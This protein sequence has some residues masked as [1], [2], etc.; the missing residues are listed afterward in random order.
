MR[1][2]FR[3]KK[4]SFVPAAL[5]LG[6]VAICGAQQPALPQAPSGLGCVLQFQDHYI[7]NREAFQSR[8]A[9]AQTVAVSVARMELFAQK[10]VTELAQGLGKEVVTGKPDLVFELSA[11]DR[12][13]RIDFGPSDF[14]LATLTVYEPVRGGRRRIWVE[15]FD[16]QED[17]PWPGTVVDLIRQF[18]HNALGH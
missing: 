15:T 7:C 2:K 8:L 11:I 16:G 18:K 3:M 1:A 5:L 6:A 17:R 9:R 14:A 13:G 10:Q 12:S 4:F